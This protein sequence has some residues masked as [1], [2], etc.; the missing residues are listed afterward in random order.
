MWVL[1]P[2]NNRYI[3]FPRPTYYIHNKKFQEPRRGSLMPSKD[4]TRFRAHRTNFTKWF[5]PIKRLFL[6]RRWDEEPPA[7]VIHAQT[8]SYGRICVPI[9]RRARTHLQNQIFVIT[10]H[11]KLLALP[12]SAEKVG[13][14]AKLST[15]RERQEVGHSRGSWFYLFG[16]G[17]QRSFF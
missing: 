6:G 11:E 10:E 3:P 7:L 4:H 5:F 8:I 9:N 1:T 12:L 17:Y 13:R 15:R 2:K 14:K 16:V